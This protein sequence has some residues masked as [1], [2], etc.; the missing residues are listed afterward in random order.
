LGFL[1]RLFFSVRVAFFCLIFS[2][3]CLGLSSLPVVCRR[4]FSPVLKVWQAPQIST[5]IS[6]TVDPISMIFPQAQI[7]LALE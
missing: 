4:L 3:I 5:F 2:V 1:E 7:I 6:E